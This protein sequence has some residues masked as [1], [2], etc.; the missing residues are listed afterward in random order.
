MYKLPAVVNVADGLSAQICGLLANRTG[1]VYTVNRMD[2][3]IRLG[4]VVVARV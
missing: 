2:L 1:N 4:N 3:Y